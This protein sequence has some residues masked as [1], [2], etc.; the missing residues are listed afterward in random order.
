MLDANERAL[1]EVVGDIARAII[2]EIYRP[3]GRRNTKRTRPVVL[4]L[5]K[6]T[7]EFQLYLDT[8]KI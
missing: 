5:D 6:D 8:P 2:R 1:C 3:D 4:D 7:I